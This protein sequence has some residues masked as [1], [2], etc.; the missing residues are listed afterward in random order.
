METKIINQIEAVKLLE[1]GKDISAYL[2]EFNEEKMEPLQAILLSKN[3][4]KVPEHL[5]YFDE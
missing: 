3:G 2:V 1:E 4:I 5:I